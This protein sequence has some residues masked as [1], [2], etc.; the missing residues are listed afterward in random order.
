M[1]S[2]NHTRIVTD[3][4]SGG[5]LYNKIVQKSKGFSA[6]CFAEDEAARILRQILVAASYLHGQGI[7]HR[8][9]KPENIMF[10]TAEEDS[11]IKIID[12]DLS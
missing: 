4:Y 10:A 5:E 12:F 7:V 11:P 2:H 9:L 1:H 8:D 6:S 3:L